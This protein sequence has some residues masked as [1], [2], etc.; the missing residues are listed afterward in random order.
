MPKAKREDDERIHGTKSREHAFPQPPI[1]PRASIN[2][3]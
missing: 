3:R 1:E 2:V